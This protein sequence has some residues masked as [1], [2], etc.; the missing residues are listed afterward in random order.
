MSDQQRQITKY[1]HRLTTPTLVAYNFHLLDLDLDEGSRQMVDQTLT[2]LA[3]VTRNDRILSAMQ[4]RAKKFWKGKVDKCASTSSRR[5]KDYEQR[6]ISLMNWLYLEPALALFTKEKRNATHEQR[7][8]IV[9][10]YKYRAEI[11]LVMGNYAEAFSLALKGH[12]CD[13]T[14]VSAIACGDLEEAAS[15][16]PAMLNFADSRVEQTG[17]AVVSAFETLHLIIL[18][19]IAVKTSEEV[20]RL[21]PEVVIRSGYDLGKI[22]EIGTLFAERRFSELVALFD[23]ISSMLN[24]SLYTDH[25]SDSIMLAIRR[26]VVVNAARPYSRISFKELEEMTGLDSIPTLLLAAIS[27]NKIQGQVDMVSECFLGNDDMIEMIEMAR[28]M[29][30]TMIIKE[31]LELTQ[32]RETY[33]KMVAK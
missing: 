20:K 27:D 16:I 30:E 32:M 28:I 26:N 33:A 10:A 3:R 14:F 8:D 23:D 7:S 29:N 24:F 18:V 22:I 1:I 21:I 12:F 13:L 11:N 9:L 31:V 25:V 5:E 15:L 6:A 17:V 19:S 4:D 2:D